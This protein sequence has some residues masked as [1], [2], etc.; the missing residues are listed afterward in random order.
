MEDID[1]KA[2]TDNL[3]SQLEKAKKEGK[4][5]KAKPKSN[6]IKKITLG[7]KV[8]KLLKNKVYGETDLLK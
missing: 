6:Y 8:N 2:T 7:E 5:E 1:I 3:L 4:V